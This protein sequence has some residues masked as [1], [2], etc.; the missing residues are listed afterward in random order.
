MKPSSQLDFPSKTMENTT[1]TE[2]KST[3]RP[4]GWRSRSRGWPRIRAVITANGITKM[5]ICVLEPMAIAMAVATLL[6]YAMRTADRCSQALPTMG[7][8]MTPTK[9]CG[10]PQSVTRPSMASTMYSERKATMMV[11]RSRRPRA[12]G[13]LSTAGSSCEPFCQSA[14]TRLTR[15]SCPAGTVVFLEEPQSPPLVPSRRI[16]RPL[17]SSLVSSPT[18]RRLLVKK[19]TFPASVSLNM[20]RSPS[21][22]VNSTVSSSVP[23]PSPLLSSKNSVCVYSWNT[24]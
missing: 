4:V 16:V 3:A 1:S 20:I 21:V 13:T 22:S 7:R 8:R 10:T 11:L 18:L 24:K 14:R 15:S 17:A 19:F 6:W 12:H 2:M 9:A 5:A 23:S